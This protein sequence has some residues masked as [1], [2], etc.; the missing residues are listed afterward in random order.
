MQ[1]TQLTW[2]QRYSLWLQQALIRA[3]LGPWQ[4]NAA[5]DRHDTTTSPGQL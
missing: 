3:E 1:Q 4:A 2:W 5:A